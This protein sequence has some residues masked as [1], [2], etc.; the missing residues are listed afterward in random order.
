MKQQTEILSSSELSSSREL[1][2]NDSWVKPF[3]RR[4]KKTLALALGLGVLAALFATGLM[5]VSGDL[6]GGSAF[7]PASV[8]LLGSPLLFVRIFGVGKPILQ[9]FE[10]LHSHD[11]VLRMTSILRLKLWGALEKDAVFFR[12]KY[13][14]GDAIGLLSEDIGHIQNLYLRTVFPVVIAWVVALLICAG[15]G[16]LT[17][18]MGFAFLLLCFIE[19]IVVPLISVA[20]NGARLMKRKE[21]KSHLYADLTDNVLGVSDWIFSGRSEDYQHRHAKLQAQVRQVE[22]AAHRFDRRRDFVVQVLYVIGALMAIVWAACVFVPGGGVLDGSP[23]WILAFVLG[24]FPLLET[25]SPVPAAAVEL[26]GHE[27]SVRNL[28]GLSDEA[29]EGALRLLHSDGNMKDEAEKLT[30]KSPIAADLVLKIKNLSFQYETAGKQVIKNLNL[31]IRPGEHVAILGR[32]GSGK[33]T[34][35][36]LIRGDLMPDQGSVT[37]G[38]IAT[39]TLEEMAAQ[40][41]GVIQQDTYLFN[42]SLRE[43][44]RLGKPDASDEEIVEALDRVGLSRLLARLPEGLD[45]IVD[46]AGLRFSGGERHRIALA[47]VLLQD[48]PF[49]I[50]DEPTVG[51]DPQTE[52]DVLKVLLE[53]LADKTVLMITHHLAGVAQMDKVLFMEAG[54]IK[55][56]GEVELFASPTELEQTSLFYRELVAFD[57]G[58]SYSH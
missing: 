7:M 3:F 58:W 17:W 25:F 6:I 8:L 28:N 55:R 19:L 53:V 51:L 41:F 26:R 52:R 42:T 40:Y 31:E 11:W 44:L 39:F 56:D 24:Y 34:L 14:L 32:S 35:A 4:Y 22:A 1:W 33:S 16:V 48:V 20:I 15:L 50:L 54:T 5:F 2:K 23:N 27:S 13:R 57:V 47:R 30:D 49:V 9:Y 12:G 46:E 18:W 10:R 37:I 36:T 38:G 21:Y 29:G 45:T 43:N